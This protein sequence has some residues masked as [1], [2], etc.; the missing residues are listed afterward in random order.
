[1]Q[2]CDAAALHIVNVSMRLYHGNSDKYQRASIGKIDYTFT[3]NLD[4]TFNRD[5][6]TYFL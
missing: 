3:L 2:E 4:K 1:M 6:P 5:I